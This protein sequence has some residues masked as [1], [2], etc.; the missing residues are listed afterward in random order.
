MGSGK[1]FSVFFEISGHKFRKND[2]EGDSDSEN[3]ERRIKP[4]EVDNR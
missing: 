1:P 4:S 3:R 2:L